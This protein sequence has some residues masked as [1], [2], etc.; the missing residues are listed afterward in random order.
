MSTSYVTP[1]YISEYFNFDYHNTNWK[2]DKDAEPN[3]AKVQA[4]GT[5]KLWNILQQNNIALLADEVGTGK[6]YQALTIA[7]MLWLQKP[8]AKIIVYA[9]NEHVALNWVNE[10]D[11]FVKYH[12][13]FKDNKIKSALNNAPLRKAIYCHNHVELMENLDRKSNT[14]FVCKTSSL[15]NLFSSTKVVDQYS[16]LNLKVNSD[17][18]DTN[19]QEEAMYKL[20][21]QCNNKIY[22]DFTQNNNP[23]IDLIIFDEAHYLRNANN[24]SNRAIV[25]NAFFA[26]KNIKD[27]NV[28]KPLSNQVLLLT[29]TPNH[30]SKQDVKTIVDLF[31]D[32]FKNHSVDEILDAICL[33]RFKKLAG[34]TKYSYRHEMPKVIDMKDIK[35]KLFFATYQ[36]T[37]VKSLSKK[38]ENATTKKQ[39]PYQIFFGYLEG[40]EFLSRTKSV[41]KEDKTKNNMPDDLYDGDADDSKIIHQLCEVYS[42][43]K[44]YN[45]QISHPKYDE[46][47]NE[48]QPNLDGNLFVEK[49]L[50]F[51]RRI[52]SVYEISTK[53]ILEYDKLFSKLL[54]R[55]L[56]LDCI[57]DKE[58]N[59]TLKILNKNP[60]Y[61]RGKFYE[62]IKTENVIDSK[63]NEDNE[64]EIEPN[65]IEDGIPTSH[66]L[67]LFTIK[68]G[69]K[70]NSTDCSNF[71]KRLNNKINTFYCLFEPASDYYN[72][73]YTLTELSKKDKD[74]LYNESLLNDRIAKNPEARTLEILVNNTGEV[75][76][77]KR[78]I[79]TPTIF[80]MLFNNNLDADLPYLQEAKVAY[81]KFSFAEK[82]AFSKYLRKGVLHSSPYIV[83]FY[84][85]FKSIPSEQK[86]VEAYQTFCTK[87]Q[88]QFIGSG[89]AELICSA[90]NTFVVFYKKEN[91]KSNLLQEEWEFLENTLPVYPV[92][93]ATKRE[94]ILKAFNTPFYPNVLVATSVLQEGVNLHYHCNKVIH[95]GLA[96]TPG[97]IEQRVGRVDRLNGK[98]EVALHANNNATLDIQYPYLEKTLDEDQIK[99][100]IYRKH[101][102][103]E[104][105]DK[106]ENIPFDKDASG[107]NDTES[108]QNNH[109]HSYFQTPSNVNNTAEKDGPYPVDYTKDF[110]TQ[111]ALP[112]IAKDTFDYDALLQP[113]YNQ[114]HASFGNELLVFQHEDLEKNNM[115]FALK[116]TRENGR[117]QPIIAEFTY[118]EKGLSVLSKPVYCLRLKTPMYKRGQ[119]FSDL[120]DFGEF[121]NLY[122]NNAMLKICKDNHR[123]DK[124]KYYIAA[125]LPLFMVNKTDINISGSEL[126]TTI[127]E[128]IA[129]ADDLENKI[130]NQTDIKNAEAIADAAA[131]W[132]AA[133]NTLLP[134]NR[135]HAVHLKWESSVVNKTIICKNELYTKLLI[136]DV[137]K[138]LYIFNHEEYFIKYYRNAESVY[139][140]V[141]LYAADALEEEKLLLETIFK[142]NK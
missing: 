51:V 96:W 23:P 126:I 44:I 102:A 127:Y 22:K 4:E 90:I 107:I 141:G 94:T 95:Y 88:V 110:P 32:K 1:E 105:I 6:T 62:L 123:S 113:I 136:D 82:E 39:N 118:Y 19:K 97:D 80:T 61:L 13:R 24:G 29:A 53:L 73:P 135:S 33:R 46:V 52:A 3:I 15:S 92:C 38:N 138:D 9:P 70:F 120:R 56:D 117:D 55:N 134:N 18:N 17:Y 100:F 84:A 20:A 59:K 37:L 2:Y 30:S 86:S 63:I 111:I 50:I 65:Q 7:L 25:A 34:K 60:N 109:W 5:A 131:N 130:N 98:M 81:Q 140:T 8:D 128:L 79:E 48:L 67:D 16:Y 115:L 87:L 142:E 122:A 66:F 12:Y 91:I 72:K 85:I 31:C 125:D 133:S 26:G 64:N 77:T 36:R 139:H 40:F 47:I 21:L 35:A 43:K 89:L 68:R 42:S 57:K 114:L 71:R 103:E 11:N 129:F 83:L 28:N 132:Q 69:T 27:E 93:A 41:V 45:S 74:V 14:F 106:M 54:N 119:H 104:L 108:V 99:R 121:K 124:F 101:A 78:V 75:V 112:T 116:H 58:I 49:K 137:K 76:P 10:Y